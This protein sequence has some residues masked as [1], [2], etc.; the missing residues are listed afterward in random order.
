MVEAN[1][2]SFK[3]INFLIEFGFYLSTFWLKDF[4]GTDWVFT[5]LTVVCINIISHWLHQYSQQN[6]WQA[7]NLQLQTENHQTQTEPGKD[8]LCLLV[9]ITCLLITTFRPS[10]PSPASLSH[11]S[12]WLASSESPA[13]SASLY[14]SGIFTLPSTM[15]RDP[16]N[17]LN[18]FPGSF[19]LI[20]CSS[21]L[22][23]D[24]GQMQPLLCHHYQIQWKNS[25]YHNQQLGCGK[26][27]WQQQ[28]RQRRQQQAVA[29]AMGCGSGDNY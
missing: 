21:H 7:Q 19:C 2:F 4:D 26:G 22:V 14:Y 15:R 12:S 8:I 24:L 11:S 29:E 3:I 1:I 16:I 18:T 23:G 27:Q 20:S 13:S 17:T 6:Q 10:S 9:T 28:Q 25:Q 5:A